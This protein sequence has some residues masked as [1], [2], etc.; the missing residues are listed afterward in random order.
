MEIDYTFHRGIFSSKKSGRAKISTEWKT[1][2]IETMARKFRE[3]SRSG[4][5]RLGDFEKDRY[6]LKIPK[7][8]HKLV[9]N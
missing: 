7:W 2:F 9:R 4:G 6:F 3:I 1:A 8:Q 5:S